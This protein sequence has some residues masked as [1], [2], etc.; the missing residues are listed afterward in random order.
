MVLPY[1]IT[2]IEEPETPERCLTAVSSFK[3]KKRCIMRDSSISSEVVIEGCDSAA[4]AS[5]VQYDDVGTFWAFSF[6]AW[7]MEGAIGKAVGG[8]A[9]VDRDGA[10]DMYIRVEIKI[11]E[12]FIETAA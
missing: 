4:P 5:G 3:G 9:L 6:G 12:K 8:D 2:M 1:L 7:N 10:R 11:N